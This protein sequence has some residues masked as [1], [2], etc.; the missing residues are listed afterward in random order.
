MPVDLETVGDAIAEQLVGASIGDV[1]ELRLQ[2]PSSE[3]GEEAAS[4]SGSP[5]TMRVRIA[6]VKAKEKPE[7]DDE[8]AKTLGFEDWAAVLAEIRNGLEAQALDQA[9]QAQREEL[10]EKLLEAVDVDLPDF[11]VNRRRMSLLQNLSED[12]EQRNMTLDDYVKRLEEDGKREEF[13]AE[14]DASARK[15]V[16][17]ELVLEKLR[18]ERGT[19]LD[20]AEFQEAVRQLAAREGMDP[21]SFRER[22]GEDWMSNYRT[23]LAR[24]KALRETV[25]ELVGGSRGGDAGREVPQ[26]SASQGG[27][28]DTQREER[29]SGAA[30]SETN[31]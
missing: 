29:E 28:E 20:D 16:K 11:L 27:G 15:G 24:D 25:E 30:P 26:A 18:E 3:S 1:V 31:P 21:G 12:L 5:T 7:A 13:D 8:F 9:R 14:L 10:V 23:L 6:D 4:E 2:D 17:R 22:Q 19:E